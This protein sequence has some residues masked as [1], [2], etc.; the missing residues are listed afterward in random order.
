MPRLPIAF[1]ASLVV[2]CSGSSSPSIATS[3]AAPA[4]AEVQDATVDASP[5]VSDAA[6]DV[7]KAAP[8][9]S[10]FGAQIGS[11]GFARFDGT[12][13][14]ILAPGNKTCPAPNSTHLVLELSFA[15]AVYRMVVDVDD[16]SAQ[17]TIHAHTI[18]H[19]A[20]GGPWQD[21][22]HDVP[23]DYVK[24]LGQK[25]SDFA[26]TSTA[27]AV[28]SITNALSLGAHVSVFATAQGE[29][30]SAH[31]VHRNAPNQDG[32]I[33]VDPDSAAPRWLLLAFADQVF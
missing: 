32:A 16:T 26:S 29:N 6:A 1:A 2:A 33:V 22:W 17:G 20:I 3:D 8:C 13:V 11:V 30:D 19:P 10:S 25:S 31:L 28:A 14:A 5:D 18:T 9:V 15:G 24:D 23:L 7:D 27:D 21:G 4:D 12:V